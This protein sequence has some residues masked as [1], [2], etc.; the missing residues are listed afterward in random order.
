MAHTS[1]R[2]P[3]ARSSRYLAVAAMLSITALPASATVVELD[4]GEFEDT[5]I[6]RQGFVEDFESYSPGAQLA[7]LKLSNG[8]VFDSVAP[9]ITS[10]EA[11]QALLGN[12]LPLTASRRFIAFAPDASLVGMDVLL[13]DG[14]EFDVTVTL[15]SGETLVIE[16]RRGNAF[17]GFFGILL[18]GDSLVSIS[19]ENVGGPSGPGSGGG[20]IGNFGFDNLVVDA[21]APVPVPA[22]IL[23]LTAPLALLVRNRR[24]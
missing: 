21:M 16:A 1:A 15:T 12:D 13:G 17:D 7:P 6:G 22:G 23:L 4:R 14:D 2:A 24:R 18:S 9:F 11:N 8:V 5:L 19:F 10:D 20:G 3:G